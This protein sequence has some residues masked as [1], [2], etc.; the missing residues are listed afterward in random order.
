MYPGDPVRSPFDVA[1]EQS[2]CF[3]HRQPKQ[4]V[5][6]R[7]PAWNKA[8]TASTP[9][10]DAT[11]TPRLTVAVKTWRA[12]NQ[13]RGAR[14]E[15]PHGIRLEWRQPR[16]PAWLTLRLTVVVD[17]VVVPS[18]KRGDT[19]RKPAWNKGGMASTTVNLMG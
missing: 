9:S 11:L 15:N 18:T 19:S 2:P 8:E 1:A 16:Q 6:S 3:L 17:D 5:A 14:V 7:K 10:I 12:V 13:N 4:G